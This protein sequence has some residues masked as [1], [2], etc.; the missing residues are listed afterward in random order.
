MVPVRFSSLAQ[1]YA[2]VHRFTMMAHTGPFPKYTLT[3]P[4]IETHRLGEPTLG[5]EHPQILLAVGGPGDNPSWV[6]KHG[7]PSMTPAVYFAS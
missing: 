3:Q 7:Y 6:L 2:G 4:S 5:F 1:F